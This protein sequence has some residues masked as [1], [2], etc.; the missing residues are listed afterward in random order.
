MAYSWAG[1]VASRCPPKSKNHFSLWIKMQYS[2]FEWLIFIPFSF[3]NL[4]RLLKAVSRKAIAKTDLLTW[5]LRTSRRYI[6]WKKMLEGEKECFNVLLNCNSYKSK[7]KSLLGSFPI[8]WQ[9]EGKNSI[10]RH[11]LLLLH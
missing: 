2:Y 6:L 11:L 10:V 9:E 1:M 5:S 4:Y 8:N 3:N 7:G